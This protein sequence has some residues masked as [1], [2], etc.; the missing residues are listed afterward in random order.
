MKLRSNNYLPFLLDYPK[1]NWFIVNILSPTLWFGLILLIAVILLILLLYYTINSYFL[2][3]LVM[4]MFLII[5]PY[6][7]VK[8]GTSTTQTLEFNNDVLVVTNKLFPFKYTKKYI[9]SDLQ[10]DYIEPWNVL[11][12]KPIKFK[13][14][15]ARLIINSSVKLNNLYKLQ[16][17]EKLII[18]FKA[19]STKT[20]DR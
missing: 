11:T 4:M 5:I 14:K 12:G 6:S 9:I 1:L 3:P 8:N 7:H 2:I 15:Y 19:C 10:V 13:S 17:L 20:V 18:E 16:E